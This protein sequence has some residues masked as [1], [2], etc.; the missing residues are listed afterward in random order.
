MIYLNKRLNSFRNKIKENISAHDGSFP[1][2]MDSPVISDRI[3]VA[4][5]AT[6]RNEREFNPEWVKPFLHL[7]KYLQKTV[8]GKAGDNVIF[9]VVLITYLWSHARSVAFDSPRYNKSFKSELLIPSSYGMGQIYPTDEEFG[10]IVPLILAYAEYGAKN[11]SDVE[12]NTNPFEINSLL[13]LFPSDFDKKVDRSDVLIEMGL[14]E[15]E[16]KMYSYDDA[17]EFCKDITESLPETK[18]NQG[19]K[20]KQLRMNML[21]ILH[22]HPGELCRPDVSIAVHYWSWTDRLIQRSKQQ[23]EFNDSDIGELDGMMLSIL[24][25]GGQYTR[26]LAYTAILSAI[27][28][29]TDVNDIH[30]YNRIVGHIATKCNEA[31]ITSYKE[32]ADVVMPLLEHAEYLTESFTVSDL[33]PLQLD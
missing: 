19:I 6:V 8:P 31:S 16:V 28:K 25:P 14:D 4:A 5:I 32:F 2:Y 26:L 22:M 12:V 15:P 7:H 9:W 29:P 1:A 23:S 17:M 20:Y 18:P 10:K 27:Y 21:R 11:L 24:S 13:A 3:I 33:R 30:F